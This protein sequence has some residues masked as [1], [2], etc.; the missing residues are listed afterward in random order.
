M[1]FSTPCLSENLSLLRGGR[2]RRP[3]KKKRSL[4]RSGEVATKTCDPGPGRGK[5][6]DFSK[7][8]GGGKSSRRRRAQHAEKPNSPVVRFCRKKKRGKAPTVN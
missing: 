6:G 1:S 4:I 3:K 8:G 2:V 7:K 5:G